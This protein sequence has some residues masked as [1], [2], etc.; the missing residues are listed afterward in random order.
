[1]DTIS[2][3][4]DAHILQTVDYLIKTF[5][6]NCIVETGTSCADTTSVLGKM[7]PD[8]E[9]HTI[10]IIEETYI[11]S[12][13]KLAEYKNITCYLGS[14]EKILDEILPK[15]KDKKVMFYLDAHWYDYWPIKDEL[16]CIS[17]VFKDNALVVIDDF[18]VPLRNFQCDEYK[19]NALSIDYIKD[20]MYTAY[21]NPFFFF[22]EKTS[23]ARAVGKIYIFPSDWL[24]YFQNDAGKIWNQEGNHYYSTI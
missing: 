21:T 6:I 24:N 19:G 1:M 18:A 5:G 10:E 15:L 4:K 8:I 22:N 12:K 2:F 11:K 13:E 3:N 23:L 20:E 16:I 14:S 7:Y 9:V 17:K